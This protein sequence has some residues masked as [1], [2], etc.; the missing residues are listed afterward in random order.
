MLGARAAVWWLV[1]FLLWWL[2]VGSWSVGYAVGGAAAATLVTVAALAAG[3]PA[4]GTTSRGLGWL[5]ELGSAA[6]QVALD[7]A[8]LVDV[9][10]RAVARRDRGPMGRTLVRETGARGPDAAVRRGWV[11]LVATWSPNAYV[12]GIEESSGRATLHD[13]RPWR[14]SEE[15]V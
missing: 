2:I 14:R 5:R 6:V 8:V 1:L 13:L 10:A 11:T 12:I 3:E 15:P 4:R 9:L 7:F